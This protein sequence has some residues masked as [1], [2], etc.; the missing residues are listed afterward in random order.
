MVP[1]DAPPT[2]CPPVGELLK[3]IP[4]RG[5]ELE[6]YDPLVVALGQ[7]AMSFPPD[8]RP[9]FHNYGHQ[10]MK[11]PFE[12]HEREQHPTMPD[13]IATIPSLP[14]IEPLHRWR[15]VTLVFELKPLDTDDPMIKNTYTHWGTLI[16]LAKGARNIMLSQGRLYVFLVGIYGSVARIFRFDRAGAICSAPFKYKETPSILH[17]FLWRLF[18]PRQKNCSIVGQDPTIQMGTSADRQ[19]AFGLARGLGA[20]WERTAETR[21]AVRR[22]TMTDEQGKKVTYL[23]FR[24]LFVNPGLFSRATLVWEAFRLDAKGQSSLGEHY[25]IKEGW[26]Q[27]CCIPET[28]FYGV[29]RRDGVT[30]GVASYTHGEDL[31]RH[32]D[33]IR[34][35]EVKARAAGQPLV[36]VDQKLGHLTI[37][38]YHNDTVKR[39]FNEHSQMR[40]SLH[41]VGT[42]LMDFQSTRELIVAFRDTIEGHRQAYELGGVIHR[43]ISEGNVMMARHNAVFRGFIQDFDYSFSWRRFLRKRGMEVCLAAWEKYCRERG[44]DPRAKDKPDESKERTGTVLFMAIEILK[45]EVTHEVRHDLESFYWL[46]IFIL[47]RH[48]KHGHVRGKAAFGSLFTVIDWYQFAQNKLGWIRDPDTPLIIPGNAPLNDLI[49]G[50]RKALENN[51][52]RQAPLQRIT[53]TQVL[54]LFDRALAAQ[55][56]PEDDAAIEWVC[57]FV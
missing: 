14:V 45:S 1:S 35:E 31:G 22:I 9:S 43:D 19:L 38:G 37:S 42:P 24:L 16:Q 26:R 7:L 29:L 41:T 57:L 15:H 56:W 54:A 8:K 28:E 36:G 55:A 33:K 12:I 5:K 2:C 21:K 18:H 4:L 25:V 32:D 34:Q 13:V 3:A 46:L 52:G 49:E 23:A 10:P 20:E 11:F 50:F 40:I 27:C 6:M 47:L 17:Q 39:H 51:F 53:H 44:H 30:H 48:T